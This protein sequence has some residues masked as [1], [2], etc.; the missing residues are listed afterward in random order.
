MH[1]RLWHGIALALIAGGISLPVYGASIGMGPET[2]ALDLVPPPSFEQADPILQADS[3]EAAQSLRGALYEPAPNSAKLQKAR[4][5][6]SAPVLG[7]AS[8]ALRPT[9]AV[10]V[11]K[12]QPAPPQDTA[13]KK[14]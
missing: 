2:G 4:D 8:K 7:P 13:S 11:P 12:H 3:M 6:G 10:V 1:L 9:D 14:H 5:L